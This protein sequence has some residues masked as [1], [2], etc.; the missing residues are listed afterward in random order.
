MAPEQAAGLG[1][2]QSRAT[3]VHALGAILYELL[4]GEPPFRA[5][6]ILDV[7]VRVREALPEPPRRR[8]SS[9][10]P[11]L[12]AICLKCLHKAP[13]ERYA[14]AA[15]LAEDLGRFLDGRMVAAGGTRFWGRVS[16]GVQNVLSGVRSAVPPAR[17]EPN[18]LREVLREEELNAAIGS[19]LERLREGAL[20][21]DDRG[22]IILVN[23]AARQ[24]FGGDPT[25]ST[26]KEWLGQETLLQPNQVTPYSWEEFPLARALRGEPVEAAEVF[27]PASLQRENIWLSVTAGRLAA[28]RG[29]PARAVAFCRDI[30]EHKMAR[31]QG[32]F[33]HSLAD[34]LRLNI[35]R[36]DL[37][38]RF[39][40]ANRIFCQTLGRPVDDVLG[41]TD[42][43]FFAPD[44]AKI[45]QEYDRR[46]LDSG[47][48]L[49][50]IEE[51]KS[52]IC[53]TPCRCTVP[54]D[55]TNGR[56]RADDD[57][58][59]VQSLLAPVFDSNDRLVG[60]QGI[61]WNITAQRRAERQLEQIAAELRRSNEEL[62]RFAYVASHDLSEPL[63][64][65]SSHCQLLQA[66]YQGQ[67][68][69][70]ADEFIQTAVDGAVRMQ[71]M[72]D[73]LLEYSRVTTRSKPFAEVRCDEV[74]R[75]VRDNL[76]TLVRENAAETRFGPLPRVY[77]DASQFERLF[78]NLIVNAIKFRE[79]KRPPVVEV[80][81]R[82]EGAEWLFWVRD[83][84]IGIDPR[85]KDRIFEIFK[86]LHRDE[87]PGTGIGLAIC[88]KIVEQHGGRIWV[89]PNPAGGS[90]F[91][92]TIPAGHGRRV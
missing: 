34:S 60:T 43:D 78:Q 89:E 75:L 62:D 4:T 33:Y 37:Q 45:C 25:G 86:R 55:A 50:D 88:K 14:T 39:T 36:K 17:G 87:Y 22:R 6:S 72:L 48:V 28:D 52:S 7:L 83:N 81:A 1:S 49:E 76:K 70:D 30:T 80:G 91:C 90:V 65:V 21:C 92:F 27:L 5:D 18:R 8:N 84:G 9:V 54:G 64:N 2:A 20:V 12:E 10:P 57:V 67:L 77:G 15:A 40:F 47:K 51:H 41:R 85:H 61:F 68:G 82:R 3:D 29:G 63:R 56:P 23:P 44:V 58:R 66:R 46:V 35:F 53:K 24:I 79:P 71:R 59:Y 73:D 74:C 42:F 13:E 31:E 32:G 26:L 38:G 19:L 11:D 16:S 69:G